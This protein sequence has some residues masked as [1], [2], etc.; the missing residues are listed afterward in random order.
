VIDPL[1]A[2]TIALGLA[3]LFAGAAAHKLRAYAEWPGVVRNYRLVPDAGSGVLAALLVGLEA[4]TT[5]ALL[6]P[7]FRGLGAVLAA[8]LLSAYA[9]G[10]GIN[11]RRGRTH[12]DCGCF[13]VRLREGIAPWMICRNV[14]LAALALSLCLPTSDRPLAIGEVAFAVIAVVTAAFLYPVLAV[15][16][17]R[18]A[19]SFDENFRA[20]LGPGARREA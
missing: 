9:L 14:V 3:A 2:L 7:A 10:I 5:A 17:R 8:S 11:L 18:R 4:V 20:S 12:I 15:V 16:T 6:W 1:P 13:G 19:P